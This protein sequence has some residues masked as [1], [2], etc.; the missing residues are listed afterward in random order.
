MAFWDILSGKAASNASNAAAADTYGKQKAATESLRG[1]GDEYLAGMTGLADRFTPYASAGSSA[2][3]RLLAGLG[4]GG[5]TQAFTDAYRGLPGYQSGLDTGSKA[6]TSRLNAGPGIQSGAAMKALYRYGS[7][8]ED[9]RSGDY[10]SRLMGVAGMGQQATGQ[11]VA[12]IGQGYQGQLSADQTAYSGDMQSA[13]TIGQ[14]Q[15]AGAQAQQSAFQNLMNTGAWLAGTG[16]G[17]ASSF[18]SKLNPLTWNSTGSANPYAA[19]SPNRVKIAGI[20]F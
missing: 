13:G 8:Y 10:L 20:D 3:D 6:V 19:G 2:L 14:G 18:A 16:F 9:Q 12:T 1:A 7:D 11:Q 5:D 4:L 17:G 15:V